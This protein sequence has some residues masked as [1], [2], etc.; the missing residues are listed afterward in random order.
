MSGSRT[1][2]AVE[3]A[4][5]IPALRQISG[6]IPLKEIRCFAVD[7]PTSVIQSGLFSSP[8]FFIRA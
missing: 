6:S 7:Q 1:S 2:A 8:Y 4:G 5:S 3:T